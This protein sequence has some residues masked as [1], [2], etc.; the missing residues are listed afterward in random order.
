MNIGIYNF[1]TLKLSEINKII[2]ETDLNID[3]VYIYSENTAKERIEHR[4]GLEKIINDY[5]KRNNR[6]NCFWEIKL[7]R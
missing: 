4:K 2:F 5:K 1:K 6:Y 7:A 3:E